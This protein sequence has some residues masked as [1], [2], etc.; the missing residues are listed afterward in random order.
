MFKKALA[1]VL[2]ASMAIALIGCG[3]STSKTNSGEVK[4]GEYK[5]LVVYEDDVK[6]TD[7]AYKQTVDYLLSQ[8]QT[9]ETV[10]KGTVKKDSVVVVDYVGKIQVDGKKVAFDNGSADDTTVNMATDE[11]SY[12]PGFVTALKGHKVGDEFTAKLQ[13]PEKYDGKTEVDGKSI[14]LKGQDVWF[15]FTIKGLQKTVTPK[16]TD[17]WAK[18]KFGSYGVTDV[19]SFEAYAREQMYISNVM[20]KVW[21]E[22]LE[23]CE[24]VSYD[25]K[26]RESLITVYNTNYETQLK[27]SYGVDL[28]TYLEACSLSQEDWDKQVRESV[29]TSLKEKMVVN[30]IAEK[31]KLVPTEEEYKKEAETFAEQNSLSV[32]E[33]ESQYGKSEVEYAVVYQIVQKFIVDN[34]EV[35]KGSEPTT[36]AETTAVSETTVAAETTAEETTK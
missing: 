19:K 1:V 36:A 14:E 16:L 35:K 22:F 4:I 8:S 31:E 20:T 29:E 18:E 6:V 21:T 25:D 7:K 34:V 3:S 12:I 30:A 27:N 28:N 10:K 17:D 32:E 15:T 9:T 26:E 11:S 24:V 5:G 2:S 33:L 13:F 23:S